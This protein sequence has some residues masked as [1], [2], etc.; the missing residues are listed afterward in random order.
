[1]SSQ[2]LKTL[3]LQYAQAKK[4]HDYKKALELNNRL[5]EVVFQE[6]LRSHDSFKKFRQMNQMKQLN[7][8]LEELENPEESIESKLQTQ[9]VE[10]V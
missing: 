5:Y 4:N 8:E 10:A 6:H 9:P 2:Q 1:M 7:K 3:N